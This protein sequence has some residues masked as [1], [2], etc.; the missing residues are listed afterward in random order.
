M[1]CCIAT[2]FICFITDTPFSL[3]SLILNYC[4][5]NN[6]IIWKKI[7]KWKFRSRIFLWEKSGC[8]VYILNLLFVYLSLTLFCGG[9]VPLSINVSLKLWGFVILFWMH[10]FYLSASMYVIIRVLFTPEQNQNKT[11]TILK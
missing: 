7:H 10:Y 5:C 1:T 3:F 6:S 11:R 9:N 2:L 4:Y 8:N